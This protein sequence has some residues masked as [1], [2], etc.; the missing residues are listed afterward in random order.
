MLGSNFY[1]KLVEMCRD[2][3]MKP[4]DLLAVMKFES[5]FSPSA[6]NKD[7]GASGLIQFMPQTL[8]SIGFPGSAADFRRLSGEEQLPWIKKYIQDKGMKFKS[9]HKYYVANLFPVALNLPG[10][11]NEDP[12]TPILEQNPESL[13]NGL[14]KKYSDIGAK[15]SASFERAAY[16]SNRGLD[17]GSKGSI[18]YGDL[19]KTMDDSKN[20]KSFQLA[21]SQMQSSTGYQPSES[22]P[23]PEPSMVASKIPTKPSTSL[24]GMLEKL[25]QEFSIAAGQSL[26]HIYK[27]ALP[28]HDV[29]IQISAPDYASAVEF[30]R[31]LCAA[32]DENLLSTSYPHTDGSKVEIECSING[33]EQECFNAIQEMSGLIVDVF[34][35]ATKKIGGI[36]VKA[37][38]IM[39]KKSSYQ[40]INVKTA[41]INYRI[42][43]LKFI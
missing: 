37:D 21:I 1:P 38:C 9:A 14:S 5:G 43:Q 33:P 22:A 25:N 16:K 28:N 2:V 8:R 23:T 13:P 29:L 40:P 6:Y 17:H 42:F 41:C 24:V 26:K 12:N 7:G 4:E 35:E 31:V 15:V 18:T 34:K 11:K 10:V 27:R 32:L 19:M 39:N 3:G 30:S 20:S 36:V